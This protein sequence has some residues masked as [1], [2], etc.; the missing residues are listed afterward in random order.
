MKSTT[1]SL[2]TL[3]AGN[4]L[5]A[6]VA[7][8]VVLAAPSVLEDFELKLIDSRFD[9][10][11]SLGMAPSFSDDIVHINIDNFTKTKS[12]QPIWEKSLYAALIEKIAS[13]RPEAIAI[14]IMF[15]D[16]ADQKGNDSLIEAAINSG[17]LISPFLFDEARG[18]SITRGLLRL[19][20][21]PIPLAPG[22]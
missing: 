11:Q 9:A 16:W 21:T 12:G 14:D 4:A 7:L 6:A 2:K 10:R 5:V 19:R 18:A 22:T 3:F 13:A 20:C 8:A 17:N 1:F 15:V